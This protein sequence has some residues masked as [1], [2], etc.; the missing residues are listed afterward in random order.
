M[1]EFKSVQD[2]ILKAAIRDGVTTTIRSAGVVP[3]AI[4]VTF[5]KGIDH[6]S[7]LVDLRP[8]DEKMVLSILRRTL[9]ELFEM[10]YR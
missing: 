5:T 2:L 10:P 4:E 8:T 1:Y 6:S 3:N 7:A 9:F